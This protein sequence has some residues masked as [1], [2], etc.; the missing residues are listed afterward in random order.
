M[1]VL[2]TVMFAGAMVLAG[3]AY[4]QGD[5]KPKEGMSASFSPDKGE[6]PRDA[7]ARCA[8]KTWSS[9][10]H[11]QGACSNHGGVE[12]WFGKPPK[13]ATARCKDGTYSQSKSH[14]GSCSG[15]GGAWFWLDEKPATP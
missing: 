7:T 1:R 13:G 10:G 12:T 3:P 2:L 14:E 4:A 9:A 11:K 5:E 8:D 15:H 6:M